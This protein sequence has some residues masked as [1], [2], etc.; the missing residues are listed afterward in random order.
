MYS[1]ILVPVD[2][3]ETSAAGL[4]EAVRLA[5][6]HGSQLCLM[7]IVNEFVLDC[8]WAPG[9]YSD[10]LFESLR[11]GGEAILDAAEKVVVAQ[12]I[13]PTRVMVESIGGIAADL[14][15]EQAKE[16]HADVIVMGTHGRRGIFRLAMGSD[17]EQVVRGATVPV[18]LV[19]GQAAA[20]KSTMKPATAAA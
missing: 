10:T 8:T 14:I 9:L 5:K 20:G 1:K 19:R 17:A 7:H 4:S 3:S 6:I 15:L 11:K 16:W 12:G 18:L 2:G 13:R